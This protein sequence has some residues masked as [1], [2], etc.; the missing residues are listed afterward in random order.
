[1]LLTERLGTGPEKGKLRYLFFE[2]DLT[3]GSVTWRERPDWLA[4]LGDLVYHASTFADL[5]RDGDWDLVFGGGDGT[6]E[7]YENIG[8]TQSPSWRN[9]AGVFPGIAVDSLATPSFADIDG[10]G[11]LDL[12]VGNENGELYFYRNESTVPVESREVE[13]PRS[14]RL[15]QNY[16]NPFNGQ[17]VIRFELPK[18]SYVSLKIYN[19]LGQEVATLVDETLPAGMHHVVWSGESGGSSVGSGVYFYE[20]RAGDAIQRRKLVLMR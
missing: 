17:T 7:F 19:L 6:L 18:M 20:L 13:I 11:R 5:D 14:F 10:D 16:P 8:G 3:S 1:M 2:N 9:R 15:W 4:G 12:F